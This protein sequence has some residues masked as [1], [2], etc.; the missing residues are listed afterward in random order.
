MW[1]GQS[2]IHFC[3]F[4]GEFVPASG[5]SAYQRSADAR[6]SCASG[7]SG[8]AMITAYEYGCE[9]KLISDADFGGVRN[10]GSDLMKSAAI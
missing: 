6:I 2:S 4:S 10:V 1:S 7:N 3:G 8:L 5:E 9:I